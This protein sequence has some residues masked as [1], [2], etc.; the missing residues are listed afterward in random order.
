ME[1]LG[2]DVGS[3]YL[4]LWCEDESHEIIWSRCIHH[5]G[6]PKKII[7]DELSS[8]PNIPE[9]LCFC[10]NLG[11]DALTRWRCDGLLAEIDYLKTRYPHRDLLIFGA[12]KIE[13]VHYDD[14][15]RILSLQKNPACAAGTGSF[16]D[17]Q[18]GRLGLRREDLDEIPIDE[19]APMV[20]SRCAVFA[21]TDLIHLQQEGYSAHAM[22]N[23]LC[24]GLV[25]SGLKS[26]FGGN[27]PDG[28]GVLLSGGLIS[29]PHIRH[30]LK[31][32]LPQAVPTAEP[33][34]LRARG[35]CGQ[36]RLHN[37][38]TDGFIST[39]KEH[40][41]ES[42]PWNEP[43]KLELKKSRFPSREILRRHDR[44]GNEIW[45][46]MAGGEVF[47]A[48]LGVDIGS[49]STKA[50]LVDRSENIRLDIYTATAGNPIQAARRIFNGISHLK[51]ALGISCTIKGCS[52]TGSGRKLIGKIIG[53]DL[54]INEISAHAK[55]AVSVD[56]SVET[57]F[58]IGGQDAKFI[59]MEHGRIVD[60]NM[61]YVCA[62]GTGSFVEEQASTLGMS[63]DEI[64]ETVMGVHPL[65]NSDRC[66]V[67]MNQEITAQ[68]AAG[69]PKDRVMAGVMLA[70]FKNYLGRVVGNRYH[71]RETIVFQGA[72]AR[73]K[74]LVAALEQISGA[75][76]KV[77]PFCHV[78]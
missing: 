55:G 32:M 10:G 26:V 50:V 72:T 24:K 56:E 8:A 22:Y 45:H 17:E 19:K 3:S 71:K 37:M 30:F 33:V 40:C 66:T 4:K 5:R 39:L 18:I 43:M 48:Y 36:A 67:F 31:A 46:D 59:R 11:G 65:A 38:Q 77:S 53:A 63:L 23:G 74:G 14:T 49:T 12:E 47:D 13:L 58:E 75:T 68:L 35:V 2:I 15:G 16:L 21:K 52:T 41:I 9:F 29:N 42:L 27:I 57:I 76:V 64:G 54:I 62:A 51:D 1:Y 60:V 73:N 20:A 7:L 70:V 6:S 61:N 69:Y 28:D 34:F 25:V 78:M 44:F